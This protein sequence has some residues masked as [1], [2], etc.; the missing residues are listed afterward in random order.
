M[1]VEHR[2]CPFLA[3]CL[4][5]EKAETGGLGKK[6]SF[7]SQMLVKLCLPQSKWDPAS[8]WCA[9]VQWPPI[10]Y[11]GLELFFMELKLFSDSLNQEKQQPSA[12]DF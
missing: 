7:R 4:S 5:L 6:W 12:L 10:L 3:H 1:Q 9:G 2:D 8:W 11:I